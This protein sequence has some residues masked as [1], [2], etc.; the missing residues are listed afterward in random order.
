[1]GAGGEWSSVLLPLSAVLLESGADPSLVQPGS[2]QRSGNKAFGHI[3]RGVRQLKSPG[4][5]ANKCHYGTRHGFR[6]GNGRTNAALRSHLCA[7]RRTRRAPASKTGL[8]SKVGNDS[9]EETMA[10][11]S[12]V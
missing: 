8:R 1:M 11:R 6:F 9:L 4:R 2:R 5:G 10:K 7:L 12:M 3:N